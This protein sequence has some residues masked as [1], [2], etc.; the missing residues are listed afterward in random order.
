MYITCILYLS[1]QPSS[2]IFALNVCAFQNISS[3]F[4]QA[5]DIKKE[6][7]REWKAKVEALEQQ[8]NIQILLSTLQLFPNTEPLC[9]MSSFHAF[10]FRCLSMSMHL[11][12]YKLK[13]V[14]QMLRKEFDSMLYMNM[15]LNHFERYQENLFTASRNC[16]M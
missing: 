6:C 15:R 4:T 12:L 13:T 10:P 14:L 5:A 1:Y 8:V 3:F 7:E 2:I 16:I 9:T 11:G